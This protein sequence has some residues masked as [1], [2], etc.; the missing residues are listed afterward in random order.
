[1]IDI[2]YSL[3]PFCDNLQS[4]VEGGQLLLFIHTVCHSSFL[5]LRL[6]PVP[7][8]SCH[9]DFPQLLLVRPEEAQVERHLE[10]HIHQR[11][12]AGRYPFRL[13]KDTETPKMCWG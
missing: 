13:H 12:S 1:M 11:P 2:I 3:K 9:P 10:R 5:H 8:R 6:A 7:V 4:G